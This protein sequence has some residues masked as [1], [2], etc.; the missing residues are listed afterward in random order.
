[1][2]GNATPD[3]SAY[4]KHSRPKKPPCKFSF[5]LSADSPLSK[6]QQVELAAALD[7]DKSIVTATAIIEVLKELNVEIEFSTNNITHHR[8]RKCSCVRAA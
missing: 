4:Y 3:L 5:L 6:K 7:A 2:T 8:A 1:V